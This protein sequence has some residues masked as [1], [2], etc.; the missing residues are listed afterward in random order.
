MKHQKIAAALL[1]AITASASLIPFAGSAPALT[2][3][4]AVTNS[5]GE[6]ID[7]IKYRQDDT[8]YIFGY[9]LESYDN[10]YMVADSVPDKSVTSL[11][12]YD[13]VEGSIGGTD[14]PF[15]VKRIAKGAFGDCTE[16]QSI[17]LSSNLTT[18][19]E[20]AF[21]NC[22]ALEEIVLP[23][24]VTEIG[25]GAFAQCTSLKHVVLPPTLTTIEKQLFNKCESLTEL[26]IPDSVTTINDK[27]FVLC[28]LVNVDLPANLNSLGSFVFGGCTKIESFSIEETNEKYASKD[29]ILYSKDMDTIVLYPNNAPAESFTTPEGISLIGDGAFVSAQNLKTVTLTDEVKSI[30]E[31]AFYDASLDSITITNPDCYIKSAENTI[32]SSITICA[33]ENSTAQEYA[34]KNGNPFILLDPA[35]PTEEIPSDEIPS[36][37]TPAPDGMM[38]D[39]DHS[40]TVDIMDVIKVNKF[41]L[42]S[43]TLENAEKAVSDV[44]GN[45]DIDSTDSLNI[46]KYVV[47]LIASFDEI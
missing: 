43:G 7:G 35:A 44:D 30:G 26:E 33:P 29:G 18:I 31:G 25:Y 23:E 22:Y 27:A 10:D 20:T 37:E 17:T 28:P 3:H 42:G 15:L 24:T 21:T 2:A 16:L 47:E 36:E 13:T 1:A 46:L 6:V 11:L 14:R 32:P 39:V 34:E 12:M 40:G 38:G 41:L 5:S 45:G 4:A 9:L 19:G 8:Y